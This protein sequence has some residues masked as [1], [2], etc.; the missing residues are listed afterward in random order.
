MKSKL[1]VHVV[2]KPSNLTMFARR[3]YMI[4][5]KSEVHFENGIGTNIVA[6]KL[7]DELSLVWVK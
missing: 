2:A 4:S 3:S 5:L 7:V 1:T 6:I